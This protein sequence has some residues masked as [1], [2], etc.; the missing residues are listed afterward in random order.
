MF[1]RAES[2]KGE[3]WYDLAKNNVCNVVSVPSLEIDQSAGYAQSKKSVS[4]AQ[5]PDKDG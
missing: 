5:R 2:R 1:E 3:K 4:G